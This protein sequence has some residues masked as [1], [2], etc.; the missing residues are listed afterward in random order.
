MFVELTVTAVMPA[1]PAA[2]I[3]LRIKASRGETMTVGPAPEARNS[4]VATK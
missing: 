4:A 2:A 3:W 1:R